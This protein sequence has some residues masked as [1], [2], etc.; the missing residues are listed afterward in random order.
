MHVQSDVVTGPA[1]GLAG[2][3][4]HPHAQRRVVRPGVF[5][6]SQLRRYPCPDGIS[7][8]RECHEEG[9]SMRR[10]LLAVPFYKRSAEETAVFLQHLRVSAVAVEEASWNPR[11]R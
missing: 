1:H 6:D 3:Q 2:M 7:R 10:D 4:A 9:V 5:R 8:P 11:C